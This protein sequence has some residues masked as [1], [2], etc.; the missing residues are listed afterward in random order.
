MNIKLIEG[1]ADSIFVKC[2]LDLLLHLIVYIP[3]VAALTPYSGNEIDAACF[4]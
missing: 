3:I 4:V 1:D 2:K